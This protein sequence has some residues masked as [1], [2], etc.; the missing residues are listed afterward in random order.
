MDR[1]QKTFKFQ[2]KEV[3]EQEGTF[4][5]HAATFRDKPD[6]WG[7]IIDRGAFTKTLKEGGK[8]IKSLWNHSVMEPI[9]KPIE[10]AEDDTG[11][12]F[13]IKLS[14][15]V[16]RAREVLS[17]MR[18]GVI[19]EMSIG[20]DT[21]KETYRDGARHLQEIRLWDLSPV[22][23]AADSDAVITSVKAEEKPLPNE[24]ACRL[25]N[26]DDFQDGSLRRMTR[27][28]GG[29]KYSIIMGRLEGEDTLTEQAYR[30]DKE[31]WEVSEAS[32]HCKEHDGKFEAA[33]E[34]S[35]AGRVLSAT[36]LEKVKKGLSA[37]Q[38]G[39]ESL[40]AL[41]TAVEGEEEPAKATQL[42]EEAVEQAANLEA[43]VGTLKAENEG[44]DTK[45]AEERIEAILVQ[46]RK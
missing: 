3:D 43:I 10:M 4:T 27:V 21:M 8:R 1:E 17:L 23:F 18:D 9:G 42:S 20:Y 31:V 7:D 25:R 26:P 33:E 36:N 30:Y 16:Q 12:A 39:I 14:L 24:H 45:G 2:V 35:K 28:S 29:K 40:Q 22:T 5:G 11:L 15:G 32:A 13:K 6:S 37:L 44:F 38:A 41:V 34:Q 46:L 19:T